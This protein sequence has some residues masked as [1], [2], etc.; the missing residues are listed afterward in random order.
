M[1]KSYINGSFSTAMLNNQRVYSTFKMNRRLWPFSLRVE[2]MWRIRDTR[3]RWPLWPCR[4][5]I[6]ISHRH[7]KPMFP[8]SKRHI[9]PKT[10]WIILG[11]ITLIEEPQLQSSFEDLPRLQVDRSVGHISHPVFGIHIWVRFGFHVQYY[12]VVLC[13]H[14]HCHM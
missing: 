13:G 11:S 3:V 6:G 12:Q 2:V 14:R 8:N 4:A 7:P 1:G 5:K 9:G 10:H